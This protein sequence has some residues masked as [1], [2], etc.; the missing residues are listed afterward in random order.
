MSAEEIL[1]DAEER[2]K[3]AI[4]I[5]RHS[6]TG[7]RTGRAN[8]GLVDSVRVDVYGSPT[9]LKQIASVGAPEPTQIVI[10]P[11]DPST[12]K[13]I[14]KAIIASDLGLTPQNDGRVVRLNIPA[15][16]TEVRK[17]MVARIKDLT[18]EA[19]VSVR[20]VRR[21]ANKAAD[22]LQKD[23]SMTEDECDS[24]KEAVQELTKKFE[25]LATEQAK[26]REQEV[27]DN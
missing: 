26:S 12:I 20:N 2:M 1:L 17:K 25:A 13:D 21:D 23:K 22:Q 19:K 24:V 16:S 4:H 11:Y 9:P 6:L 3:K 27:M 18:E 10:R 15:L 5:L 7:I 8:P 14:E